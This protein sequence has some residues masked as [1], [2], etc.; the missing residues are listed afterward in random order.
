MS[1]MFSRINHS[2]L[3][4]FVKGFNVNKSQR[5]PT[6]IIAVDKCVV[7]YIR[8]QV[9]EMLCI[10]LKIILQAEVLFLSLKFNTFPV[11]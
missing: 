2:V 1:I 10:L 8:T 11:D 7:R 5:N 9:V 3:K 4:S 6:H